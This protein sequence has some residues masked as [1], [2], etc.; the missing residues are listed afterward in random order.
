VMRLHN[1]N[2]PVEWQVSAIGDGEYGIG[3]H[4]DLSIFREE[5]QP[6]RLK[7]QSQP[8]EQ[9]DEEIRPDSKG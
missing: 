1:W 7:G 3:D 2:L 6:R 9:L 5:V 4:G 8:L